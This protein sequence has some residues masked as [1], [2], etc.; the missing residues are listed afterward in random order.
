M[1]KLKFIWLIYYGIFAIILAACSTGNRPLPTPF[2]TAVP[3]ET[4]PEIN[5]AISYQTKFEP[6]FWDSGT[7]K[8]RFVIDCPTIQIDDP[9]TA[10]VNF[11]VDENSNLSFNP[12]YL[13]INGIG[14]GV[15]G[16]TWEGDFQPEKESNAVVTI[17]MPLEKFNASTCNVEFQW[18]DLFSRN[19][20]PGKP[21]RP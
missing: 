10:W 18:D 7:H 1:R 2:P 9:I 4:I 5:W 11:S 20:V 17:F 12:V 21:Y 19:L 16:S 8:Y 15:L 14:P 6:H 3:P 13:R